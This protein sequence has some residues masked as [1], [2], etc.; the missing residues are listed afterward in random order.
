MVSWKVRRVIYATLLIVLIPFVSTAQSHEFGFSL[1]ASNFWGDLGGSNR[2][3]RPLFF[4]IE[5]GLTRPALGFTY[6]NNIDGWKAVRF[7]LFYASVAGDDARLDP[8]APGSDSQFRQYRNLNFKSIILEVSG[9]FEVNFMRYEIGRRR[10]RFA[11]YGFLGFGGFYFNPKSIDGKV[12]LQPLTTE[13]QGFDEYPDRKPYSLIQLAVLIGFGVKYNVNENWS[14]GFEYGHRLTWTDYMD[15]VSKTYVARE[16]FDSNM[17]P[18]EA[19]TAYDYSVRSDELDPED[20]PRGFEFVTS[21]GQQ[22]GD[23]SDNDHYVFAGLL[24]LTYTISKGKI[25]CPKF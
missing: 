2:I 17:P 14:L 16:L 21:P 10:Y 20:F 12:E 15:D 9:Q 24:T 11:P 19:G 4:D 1:G 18:G 5:L 22:R 8:P 6:R 25:Y 3:G 7:N 13:G 23:P